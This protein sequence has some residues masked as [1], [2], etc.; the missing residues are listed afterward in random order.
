MLVSPYLASLGDAKKASWKSRITLETMDKFTKGV[1]IDFF[2]ILYVCG[3]KKDSFQA[4]NTKSMND[5][6]GRYGDP[7]SFSKG[8]VFIY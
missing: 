6:I 7:L 1:L 8:W 2:W 5:T 3:E 4:T